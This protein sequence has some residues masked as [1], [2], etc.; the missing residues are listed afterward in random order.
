MKDSHGKSKA[1]L[2][3]LLKDQQVITGKDLINRHKLE[4]KQKA[5]LEEAIEFEQRNRRQKSR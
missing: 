4:E 1:T 5:I 3:S 2:D